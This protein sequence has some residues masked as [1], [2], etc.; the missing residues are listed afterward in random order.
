MGEKMTFLGERSPLCDLGGRRRCQRDD[1]RGEKRGDYFHRR[2]KGDLHKYHV[3][4]YLQ[5][6]CDQTTTPKSAMWGSSK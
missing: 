1:G 2:G 3:H 5:S 4:V 6:H